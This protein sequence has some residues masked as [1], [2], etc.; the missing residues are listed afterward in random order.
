[1]QK[2]PKVLSTPEFSTSLQDLRSRDS[3]PF[4][5]DPT[6]TGLGS[7]E[8]SVFVQDEP[9]VQ[10]QLLL[11]GS[12]ERYM[13]PLGSGIGPWKFDCCYS[14]TTGKKKKK[15][16]Q[17]PAAME[18]MFTLGL[19]RSNPKILAPFPKWKRSWRVQL[20]AVTTCLCGQITSGSTSK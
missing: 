17:N 11:G 6:K 12:R 7:V 5:S 16:K 9:E 10:K 4:T 8:H 2:S 15:K 1:M 19:V 18:K 3:A 13:V 14:S 20:K